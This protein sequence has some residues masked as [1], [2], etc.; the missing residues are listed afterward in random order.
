MV[1]FRERHERPKFVGMQ[2][3]AS[4]R[5]LILQVNEENNEMSEGRKKSMKFVLS[6]KKRAKK[7]Y[8]AKNSSAD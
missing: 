7:N 8:S 2:N 4:K 5:K 3:Y 6:T 1:G